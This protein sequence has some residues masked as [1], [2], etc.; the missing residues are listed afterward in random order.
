[1]ANQKTSLPKYPWILHQA[2]LYD[3]DMEKLEPDAWLNDELIHAILFLFIT[4][5]YREH[6]QAPFIFS[7][8]FYTQYRIGY[9]R[10]Q[11]YTK[12]EDIFSKR[13][14]LF[15]LHVNE[16]HWILAFVDV[17]RKCIFGLDSLPSACR[18]ETELHLLSLL[19]YLEWEWIRVRPTQ[20]FGA[21]HLCIPENIPK[22]TNDSDCGIY[23]CYFA[24]YLAE[25]CMTSSVELRTSSLASIPVP[26]DAREKIREVIHVYVRN[27]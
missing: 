20:H 21:W 3:Y 4:H 5:A 10:V 2:M 17:T 9:D 27:I 15:P 12:N 11:Y 19:V 1:M 7:S 25:A 6:A 26:V 13:C 23:L 16:N 22:Q 14:I 8:Y 18:A 24:K